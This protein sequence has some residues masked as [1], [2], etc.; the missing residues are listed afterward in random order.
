MQWLKEGD[1]NTKFFHLKAS[2]RRRTNWITGLLD[3]TG[4]W[5]TR[6][7]EM[8]NITNSYFSSLFTSV[9]V[10]DFSDVFIGWSKVLSPR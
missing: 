5:H 1:L 8:G 9:G 3:D 2:N 4:R 10:R 6:F 7:E